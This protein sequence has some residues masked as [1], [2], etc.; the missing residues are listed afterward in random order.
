MIK[1]AVPESG[2]M[3]ATQPPCLKFCLP[4]TTEATKTVIGSFPS[5]LS[6]TPTPE[7]L[8]QLWGTQHGAWNIHSSEFSTHH[9]L[10]QGTLISPRGQTLSLVF[11][12]V[13]SVSHRVLVQSPRKRLLF[14]LGPPCPELRKQRFSLP[15]GQRGH[16]EKKILGTKAITWYIPKEPPDTALWILRI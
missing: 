6:L 3:V 2:L 8:V 14:Q 1:A 7:G 11:S 10:S 4:T 15:N 12:Q 16:G 5:S 9:L 13:C